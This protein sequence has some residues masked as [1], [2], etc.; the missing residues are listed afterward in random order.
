MPVRRMLPREFYE[1]DP[2]LVARGLLGKILVR[3]LNSQIYVGKLLKLKP[4][5]EKKIPHPKL[6][7]GEKGLMN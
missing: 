5:M 1:R 2:A 4:I 6:T 3:R 7:K